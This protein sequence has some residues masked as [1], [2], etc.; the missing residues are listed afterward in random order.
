[1]ITVK[2]Y[3]NGVLIEEKEIPHPDKRENKSVSKRKGN[4]DKRLPSKDEQ[5]QEENTEAEQE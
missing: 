4:K 1:M 2:N 5:T 3:K